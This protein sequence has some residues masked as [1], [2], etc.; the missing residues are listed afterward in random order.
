MA[1]LCPLWK[2]TMD[3]VAPRCVDSGRLLW[4]LELLKGSRAYSSMTALG[5]MAIIGIGGILDDDDFLALDLR[6][7]QLF[8]DAWAWIFLAINTTMTMSIILKISYV[9]CLVSNLLP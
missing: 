5:L 7:V 4:A 2:T 1:M 3:Q 8:L 6:P 9:G